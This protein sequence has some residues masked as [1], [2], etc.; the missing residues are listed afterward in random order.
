MLSALK[1]FGVTFLISSLL[2]GVIA[3]FATGLVTNTMGEILDEDTSLDNIINN[4]EEIIDPEE[5]ISGDVIVSDEKV[6]EGDSF[7]FLVAV[8]DH[9]PD[10]YNDYK[11]DA[12]YMYNTDWT[13]VSPTETIGCLSTEYREK[14]LSSLVLVHINKESREFVYTYFSPSIR[15]YTTGGYITL[16]EIYEQYGIDRIAEHIYA[17]TGLNAKYKLLINGY[18]LDE[19]YSL[20]GGVMVNVGSDIYSDGTYNTMRYETTVEHIEADGSEWTEHKANTYLVG[21]GEVALTSDN[22][23]TLL[24]TKEHN[25]SELSIKEAYTVEILQKYLTYLANI[26]ESKLKIILSQLI[27]NESEWGNI[28]GLELAPVEEET[29]VWQPEPET[30]ETE[31]EKDTPKWVADTYEPDGAV[32]TTDFTMNEFEDIYELI[33]AVTYFENKTVSYPVTYYAADKDSGEYFD[34]NINSGISLYMD[35]RK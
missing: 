8:N 27:M 13:V 25:S 32:I 16:S 18:D 7:T 20:L 1:N 24:S 26:E 22:I 31:E 33:C 5:N 30:E 35:Y 28:E 2:F 9:R 23:Y 15:V 21:K 10:L 14:A 29:E 6:P 11:P 17:M 12:S 3:Y 34:A 19:L 4:S